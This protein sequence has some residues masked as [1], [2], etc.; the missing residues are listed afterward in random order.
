M[1]FKKL[2]VMKFYITLYNHHLTDFKPIDK[3]S[4]YLVHETKYNAR[5]TETLATETITKN[6]IHI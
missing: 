6:S 1:T 4:S 5:T 3:T 2:D